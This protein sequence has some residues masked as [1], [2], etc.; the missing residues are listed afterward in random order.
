M[1]KLR[2]QKNALGGARLQCWKP[3]QQRTYTLTQLSFTV[4]GYWYGIADVYKAKRGDRWIVEIF[5]GR[6]T[7][8]H[9]T[10]TLREAMRMAKFLVG[11]NNDHVQ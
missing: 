1:S 9:A 3:E 5:A 2:W 6:T 11:V 8:R 4:P 10:H 7:Q